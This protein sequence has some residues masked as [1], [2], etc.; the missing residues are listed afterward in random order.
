M[1]QLDDRLLELLREEGWSSP[2]IAAS[3]PSL[4]ASRAR[5]RERFRWL[6]YAGLAAPF[7]DDCYELTTWGQL[8]LEG[9]L[10]AAHQPRPSPTISA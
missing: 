7:A 4:H 10:D 1:Q 6:T 5:C 3:R 2:S 9:D 8:Y